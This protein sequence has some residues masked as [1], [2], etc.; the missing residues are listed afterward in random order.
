MDGSR[1]GY[2]RAERWHGGVGAVLHLRHDV[3]RFGDRC[4]VCLLGVRALGQSCADWQSCLSVASDSATITR[5]Q[6]GH[7]HPFALYHASR[8]QSRPANRL[9]GGLMRC[10]SSSAHHNCHSGAR[11]RAVAIAGAHQLGG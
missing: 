4:H 11:A 8:G 7:S 1:E 10:S 9:P 5:F 2:L 6:R 3:E